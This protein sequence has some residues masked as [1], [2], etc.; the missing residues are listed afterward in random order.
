MQ[1][2]PAQAS[3][4]PVAVSKPRR[5][6]GPSLRQPAAAAAASP[7]LSAL[8]CPPREGYPGRSGRRSK[9]K[10]RGPAGPTAAA[11]L[12]GPIEPGPV[13]VTG[14][15]ARRRPGDR[16]HRPAVH[17]P[18][19]LRRHRPGGKFFQKMV[20][21]AASFDDVGGRPSARV[22]HSATYWAERLE[23]GLLGWSGSR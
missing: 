10:R 12:W 7:T 4:A 20:M 13:K 21:P 6:I 11:H 23:T 19:P 22:R 18:A 2:Q 1:P 3:Y 8:F 9:Q 17:D 15:A 5:A 14:R 16:V